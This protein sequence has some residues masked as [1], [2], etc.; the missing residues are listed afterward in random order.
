M[1]DFVRK[2]KGKLK[3]LALLALLAIIL[4][5]YFGG[6]EEAEASA[7]PE[8][9]LVDGTVDGYRKSYRLTADDID[10]ILALLPAGTRVAERAEVA[11]A[12]SLT[13]WCHYAIFKDTD[14]KFMKGFPQ[15]EPNKSC[16]EWG[17]YWNPRKLDE[18]KSGILFF[19]PKPKVG[20]LLDKNLWIK[21][22]S[23]AQWS[24]FD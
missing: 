6:E 1:K 5:V 10:R 7:P 23:T 19:G 11:E 8:L 12:N 14:G 21:P 9:Y 4:V 13:R 15:N 2:H 18:S 16:A 20:T 24:R 17:T 3:V 22:W